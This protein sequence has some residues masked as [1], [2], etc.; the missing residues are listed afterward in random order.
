MEAQAIALSLADMNSGEQKME[1]KEESKVE[2]KMGID[3][4][5]Q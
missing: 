4:Q 1:N 3:D 2:D 5:L